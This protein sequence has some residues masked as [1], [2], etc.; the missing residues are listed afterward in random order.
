MVRQRSLG[1]RG[2]AAPAIISPKLIA[3]C[4]REWLTA[5]ALAY[6]RWKSRPR[7]IKDTGELSPTHPRHERREHRLGG[8]G[9]PWRTAQSWHRI[10]VFHG[11]REE[12]GRFR[13]PIVRNRR[14]TTTPKSP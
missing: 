8:T 12:I 10:S 4:R 1:V 14:L 9:D 11:D 5:N 6:W 7:A 3:H 2:R 13:I